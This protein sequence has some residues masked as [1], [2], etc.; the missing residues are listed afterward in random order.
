MALGLRRVDA[1]SDHWRE[2]GKAW[3][4]EQSAALSVGFPRCFALRQMW[5]TAKPRP[6]HAP[7]PGIRGRR[8]AVGWRGSGRRAFARDRAAG[9]PDRVNEELHPRRANGSETD[10]LRLPGP[11]PMGG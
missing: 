7:W 4:P 11:E 10:L 5:F 9:R 1:I 3:R 2:D 6:K 8:A